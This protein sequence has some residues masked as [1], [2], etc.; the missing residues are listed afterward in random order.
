MAYNLTQVDNVTSLGDWYSNINSAANALPSITFL[1]LTWFG[2]YVFVTNRNLS[3]GEAV[4]ASSFSTGLISGFFL[5]QGLIST[6]IVILLA[7]LT[8]FSI[9]YLMAR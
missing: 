8:M 7:V 5:F 3:P 9:L 6:N 1:I 4:L 2:I